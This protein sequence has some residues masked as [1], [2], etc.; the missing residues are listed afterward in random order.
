MIC[1]RYFMLT[2]LLVG[3]MAV[4]T[5]AQFEEDG[6]AG[7]FSENNG[8]P[9]D[10]SDR[11]ERFRSREEGEGGGTRGRGPRP[12]P[13]FEV[14]DVDGDGMISARELRTAI[15]ALKTLDTDGDGNI[16]LEEASPM[17]GPGSPGGPGGPGGRGGDPN[18]MIDRFM[19]QDAN[20]DGKLTIDE[21]DER[22]GRMLQGADTNQ[23]GAI[24]RAEL[25]AA[26]QNMRGGP[27]FGGG[28]PGGPG[29]GMGSG[30][31]PMGDADSMTKQVMAADQNGDGV[32]SANELNP[33]MA[34]TMQGADTN[35]DGTLDPKEIRLYMENARRRMEQFRDQRGA[36]G[37]F[38]P[39]EGRGRDRGNAPQE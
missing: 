25:E 11:R 15:K 33:Q 9:A 27:G 30:F 14:M 5:F 8:S 24:D 7:G 13:M 12:N 17:R 18:A 23:D 39:R 4:P 36:G 35:G 29:V 3:I 2:M 37:R 19:E 22:M 34:R 16:S 28:R 32:I 26:M 1:H 10:R 38:D 20:G 31:G 21:V 6:P